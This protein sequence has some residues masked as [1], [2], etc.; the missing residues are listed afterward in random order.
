MLYWVITFSWGIIGA[1]IFWNILSK[2][3]AKIDPIIVRTLATI[4]VLNPIPGDSG[5]LDLKFTL[6]RHAVAFLLS[7]AAV[8]FIKQRWILTFVLLLNVLYAISTVQRYK[9]RKNYIHEEAKRPESEALV[10]IMSIPVKDSFCAV[11]Y[12]VVCPI[13]LYVLYIIRP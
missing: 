7:S 1:I 5:Y 12:S 4:R 3:W 10:S 13:L 2:K 6:I 11:V 8:Y 9:Y